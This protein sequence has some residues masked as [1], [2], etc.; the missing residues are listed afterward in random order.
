[1]QGSERIPRALLEIFRV[2][3]NFW[4]LVSSLRSRSTPF[5]FSAF[6]ELSAL[7]SPRLRRSLNSWTVI[8]RE[9]SHFHHFWVL[10]AWRSNLWTNFSKGFYLGKYFST[11]ASNFHQLFCDFN[12]KSLFLNPKFLNFL[13]NPNSQKKKK[14]FSDF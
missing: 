3:W 11:K 9:N 7:P 14:K 6:T 12:F 5:S 1:M 4:C 8:F 13:S 2:C 10:R